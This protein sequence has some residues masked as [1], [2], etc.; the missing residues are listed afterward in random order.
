MRVVGRTYTYMFGNL[1]HRRGVSLGCKVVFNHKPDL[2]QQETYWIHDYSAPYL[3]YIEGFF[4]GP[5]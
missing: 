2:F 3:L 4:V 1:D 5:S